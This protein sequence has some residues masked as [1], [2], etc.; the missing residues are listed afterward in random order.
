VVLNTTSDNTEVGVNVQFAGTSLILGLPGVYDYPNMESKG[1][2]RYNILVDIVRISSSSVRI[3]SEI[4]LSIDPVDYGNSLSIETGS[5]LTV[6][7]SSQTITG[8]NLVT[9][10]YPFEVK[11]RTNSLS[12]PTKLTVGKLYLLN[13]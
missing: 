12:R 3:E 8:L 11:L 10:A 2:L 9:T 4:S 5:L 13:K 7:N 6:N 1:I